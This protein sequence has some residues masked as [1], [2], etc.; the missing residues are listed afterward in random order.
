MALTQ[1]PDFQN[2]VNLA[3]LPCMCLV[4]HSYRE[5]RQVTMIGGEKSGGC[6]NPAM[7]QGS[8]QA[9]ESARGLEL[10]HVLMCDTQNWGEANTGV[11]LQPF[12][13]AGGNI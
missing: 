5:Q 1:E 3:F 12:L 11:E 4:L 13:E 7:W 8:F 2:L 6:W 9:T 10:S